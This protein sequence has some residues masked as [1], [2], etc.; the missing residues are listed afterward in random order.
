MASV[1]IL[2]T[3]T[4]ISRYSDSSDEHYLKFTWRSPRTYWVWCLRL[5]K[6]A[7]LFILA[8]L[9]DSPEGITAIRVDHTHL[10]EDIWRFFLELATSLNK[11]SHIV[12]DYRTAVSESS[13]APCPL[14]YLSMI[15]VVWISIE[16]YS[17][18][19][20][21]SIFHRRREL[22]TSVF[23][24]LSTFHSEP[25]EKGPGN[26][27]ILYLI[28]I[29]QWTRGEGTWDHVYFVSYQHFTVNPWRRDLGT[30][31]FCILSLLINSITGEYMRF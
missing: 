16:Q 30:S 7:I 11:Y 14:W 18:R 5:H 4:E 17:R 29:S 28:S 21:L 8:I 24:I 25:G 3:E 20:L 31:V 22:G 9:L 23:C 27:C 2:G 26:I 19:A 12:V 1:R 15:Y 6:T 13:C 10:A